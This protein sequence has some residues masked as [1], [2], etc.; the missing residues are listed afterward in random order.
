[1]PTGEDY[2]AVCVHDLNNII[3]RFG[4]RGQSDIQIVKGIFWHMP[5]KIVEDSVCQDAAHVRCDHSQALLPITFKFLRFTK[6]IV[7]PGTLDGKEEG[8]VI[9]G[10]N[11]KLPINW[12]EDPEEI[13]Q[14]G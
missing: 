1:M 3:K 11:K 6:P 14:E 2:L 7:P 12:P 4:I 13:A 8:A 10:N 5:D 9:F